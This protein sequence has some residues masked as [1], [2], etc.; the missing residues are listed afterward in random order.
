MPLLPFGGQI[1]FWFQLKEP[2]CGC[3]NPHLFSPRCSILVL[4]LS[5][6]EL[7]RVV[8]LPEFCASRE[9]F[10]CCVQIEHNRNCGQKCCAWLLY[11][12]TCSIVPLASTSKITFRHKI[13]KPFRQWQQSVKSNV[14]F[15]CTGP[16]WLHWL[17][18]HEANSFCVRGSCRTAGSLFHALCLK[19]PLSQQPAL[20]PIVYPHKMVSLKLMKCTDFRLSWINI[21]E[22]VESIWG[23]PAPWGPFW[24]AFETPRLKLQSG[25]YHQINL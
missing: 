8:G 24:W 2:S 13:V 21:L 18:T 22:A 25:T 15:F 10:V 11:S 23:L 19:E 4:A 9:H 20:L 17:C 6:A 7:T 12:Q 3:Q 5:V 14:R 1:K 16:L